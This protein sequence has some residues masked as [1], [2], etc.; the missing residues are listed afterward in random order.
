MQAA[1][2][3]NSELSLPCGQG[4]LQWHDYRQG[5]HQ[6]RHVCMIRSVIS[7][8][9]EEVVYTR[10]AVC[11]VTKITPVTCD[12]CLVERPSGE[13]LGLSRELRRITSSPQS[14]LRTYDMQSKALLLLLLRT[15]WLNV[16]VVSDPKARPN[17][18]VFREASKR[19]IHQ[20]LKFLI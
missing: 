1:A 3:S 16:N 7:R 19:R 10:P 18:D 9:H 5:S 13:T 8:L 17:F 4:G 20:A 2:G 15:A 12:R 11:V 6:N 14:D